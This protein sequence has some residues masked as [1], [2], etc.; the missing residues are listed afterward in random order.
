MSCKKR[1]KAKYGS[2]CNWLRPT[3]EKNQWAFGSGYITGRCP[4][5]CPGKELKGTGG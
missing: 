4:K 2:F 3:G 5:D 1:K